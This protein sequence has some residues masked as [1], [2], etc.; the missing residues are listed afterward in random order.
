MGPGDALG[1]PVD[2]DQQLL[3]RPLVIGA[4]RD[5]EVGAVGD[6]IVLG[7]GME[8][9]DGHHRRRQRPD[10]AADDR[11]QSG[12]DLGADIDRVPARMRRR[13]MRAYSVDGDV[14]A[15]GGAVH[16]RIGA[17]HGP[18]AH[19]R[20]D[21][22][23]ERVIGPGEAGVEAVGEHRPGAA[24]PLLGGLG[25]E[26]DRS[27][28]PVLRGRQLAGGADQRGDVD[29]VAAG[30]HHRHFEPVDPGL[31]GRRGIS[32]TGLLLHRQPV[33]VG[34]DQH[35][36]PFAVAHDRDHARSADAFRHRRALGAQRLGEDPG[37]SVLLEA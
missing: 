10:L 17:A 25:D 22:E 34:A 13:A 6:D 5:L 15:V 11:L 32:E 16:Q 12:D 9:S 36:R 7:P 19:S 1:D 23:G 2:R 24:D 3:P 30:M 21:V 27:A 4:H 26:Q 35:G 29:V 14:D 18:G 37:G 33:H 28:P 8:G 20:I 31:A